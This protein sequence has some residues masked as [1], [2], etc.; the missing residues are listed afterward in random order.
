MGLYSAAWGGC[1][2]QCHV[3]DRSHHGCVQSY[4]SLCSIFCLTLTYFYPSIL[5][6]IQERL[7]LAEE[8]GTGIS[9]WEIGQGLDYFYDLL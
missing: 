1:A 9:I 2:V 5:Q 8:L 3:G 7:R 4:A 6:S